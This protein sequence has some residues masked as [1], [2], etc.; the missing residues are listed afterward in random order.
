MSGAPEK[1]RARQQE[2]AVQPEIKIVEMT[3]DLLKFRLAGV[4]VSIANSLRR[5]MM[6]EV[7]VLAVEFV[8]IEENSTPIFDEFLAHRIGLVPLWSKAVDQYSFKRD[9]QCPSGACQYC[10]ARFRID[11]V[12][13]GDG[14]TRVTGMD[15]EPMTDFS[16]LGDDHLAVK[17]CPLPEERLS[18]SENELNAVSIVDMKK[19]QALRLTCE[20]KKGIGRMHAKFNPTATTVFAYEADIRIDEDLEQR[21]SDDDRLKVV[22][23]CPKAVFDIEEAAGA[24]RVAQPG[25]CTFC[26]ECVLASD[27]VGAPGLVTITTVPN[28]FLFTV[29]GVGSRPTKDIF[30]AACK[31]LQEKFQSLDKELDYF[32]EEEQKEEGLHG[33]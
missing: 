11:V 28:T 24:I 9:C 17:A 33:A 8:Q 1:K 4:D 3:R 32:L 23:S 12:A 6:A 16:R 15:M 13:H 29:E 2:K 5:A 22:E 7:P 26:D 25:M 21:L 31:V 18:R 14:R 19:N 27:E 20:A 30:L 10:T